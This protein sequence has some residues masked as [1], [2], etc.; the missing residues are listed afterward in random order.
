[1]ETNNYNEALL[2]LLRVIVFADGVFDK[3]EE[4]AIKEICQLEGI[5]DEYYENFC[6]RAEKMP[7]KE[8]YLSGIDKVHGC[9]VEE[10]LKIF[11]WLYKIAEVDGKIHVKEVR[12]LLYSIRQAEIEFSQVEEAAAKTPSLSF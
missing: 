12:F 3:E 7:E 9:S 6:S 1:M 5:S 8:M 11:V 10:Q 2:H 4:N